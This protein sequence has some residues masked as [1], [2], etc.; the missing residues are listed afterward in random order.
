MNKWDEKNWKK[1]EEEEEEE[2]E[3]VKYCRKKNINRQLCN[4]KQI[5]ETR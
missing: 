1:K 4:K 5:K 2:E 3:K